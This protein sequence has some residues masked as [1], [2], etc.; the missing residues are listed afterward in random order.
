MLV[1]NPD[2]KPDDGEYW[3][4]HLD[5]KPDDGQCFFVQMKNLMMVNVGLLL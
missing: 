1:F 5:E 3:F 2:E 4:I